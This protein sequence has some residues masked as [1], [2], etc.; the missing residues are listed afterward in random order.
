MAKVPQLNRNS[1]L[2]YSISLLDKSYINVKIPFLFD[3]FV[4]Y[5]SRLKHYFLSFYTLGN[6][7][8]VVEYRLAK[9]KIN[10]QLFAFTFNHLVWTQN[11]QLIP[12]MAIA[13]ETQSASEIYNCDH[14]LAQVPSHWRRHYSPAIKQF[15]SRSKKLIVVYAWCDLQSIK[16]DYL[17]ENKEENSTRRLNIPRIRRFSE[18]NRRR[19]DWTIEFTSPDYRHF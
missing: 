1:S 5:L 6:H 19:F 18:L 16:R 7:E 10:K 17:D 13:H 2:P 3:I 4:H 8:P 9:H 12:K 11:H 15:S 14:E